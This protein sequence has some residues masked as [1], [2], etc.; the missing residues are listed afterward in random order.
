MAGLIEVQPTRQVPDEPRR[1]WFTSVELD[2]IV[3]LDA[4]GAPVGFQLCYDKGQGEHALTWKVGAG[5]AHSGV[6]DGESV[7]GL[8]YKASPVLVP[9]GALDI[10]RLTEQFAASS[11]EVP[12]DIVQLVLARLRRHPDA[13]RP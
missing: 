8:R 3:W 13:R 4:A 6:D 9:D 5:F 2:L 11:A 7:V 1:R 10:E 12:P